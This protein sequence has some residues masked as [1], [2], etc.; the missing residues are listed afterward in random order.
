MKASF[1]DSGGGGKKK[2]QSYNNVL[3]GPRL[4]Y[5]S[6][7]LMDATD[8]IHMGMSSVNNSGNGGNS[9]GVL[10]NVGQ[11]CPNSTS[12][13]V[14][15]ISTPNPGNSSSYA[16]VTGKPS[17]MKMNFH[18]L[19]TPAGNEIDVVVPMESIRAMS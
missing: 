18:T 9:Y 3:F 12:D 8:T 14:V 16:N 19:F 17:R 7:P 6:T 10:A 13:G 15:P 1:L 5:G 4:N 11:T 2:K